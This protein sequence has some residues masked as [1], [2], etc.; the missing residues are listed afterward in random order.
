MALVCMLA[1]TYY[2]TSSATANAASPSGERW[3]RPA[4]LP[5]GHNG[6]TLERLT[7][8]AAGAGKPL[9][10]IWMLLFDDYGW[11]DAGWHRNYTAPGGEFVPA[12]AE[13]STPHLDQMVREGINL[14]R[15]YVYKYCSPTRSALQ[16]GRNPYHVVSVTTVCRR[17]CDHR[18]MMMWSHACVEPAQR[19]S[20]YRQPLGPRI[21]LRSHSAQHDWHRHQA[22]RCRI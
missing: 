1:A 19:R 9:P 12:T 18:M 16:S 3:V 22:R 15:A 10:N 20:Q 13:V 11:A 7:T 2:C 17:E 14:N 21:R 8:P 6:G 5:V 4:R